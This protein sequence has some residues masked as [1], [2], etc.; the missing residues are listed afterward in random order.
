MRIA[1]VGGSFDPPHQGHAALLA[2]ARKAIRPDR[3]VVVPAFHA[4]L[5]GTPS[6]SAQERLDL[7]RALGVEV[8]PWEAKSKR[9]VYT[10][11]TLARY[12]GHDV[13]FVVGSDA[14]ASFPRWKDPARLKSLATWWTAA[15]PGFSGKIPAHFKRLPGKMPE[16]SSTEVRE[17]LAL[18]Q[19][20]SD[21]LPAP[22]LSMIR[23]KKLY[24][25]DLLARLKDSLNPGRYEHTLAVAG[26]ASALAR[27]WGIHG[28]KA[29]LAGLLH[30]CGRAVPLPK[31]A[32]KAA[33]LGLPEP[34][35]AH[36]WFSERLARSEF[37]VRDPE[38]LSA[39]GRHTFGALSMSPLDKVLYVA[40][41]SSPDRTHSE[42]ARLRA[43]AFDDLDEA[44]KAALC[45][46]LRH[47]LSKEAW[48]HPPSITLWNRLASS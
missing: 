21:L 30:D 27:R 24:G 26:L 4:P 10:V 39:I 1:L 19:D 32:R 47:A 17:R 37:G 29:R 14:A 22:V 34:M 16:I 44:F 7:V 35:L 43:L 38:I 6:A 23:K 41:A 15:R 40:D 46:K 20:V 31:L 18:G 11:E 8:D 28:E 5:K 42:A 36:A 13:H 9:R 12:R 33:A 48:L 3:L 45:A 25:L 2:A